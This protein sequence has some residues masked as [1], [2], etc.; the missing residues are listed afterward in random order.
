MELFQWVIE[1]VAVQRDGVND[2]YVFQIT[3]FD[4]SEKN[5]MDIARMKTKRMLKRNKIPYLRITICWVQLVAVI[6]RTKY[7][8]Y[9]QLV[10]LNKPKKV[11]T[12]LLQLSF[13]ELD[14]YERRYRK[15]RRKKHKR[16]ANLN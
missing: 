6:R 1:T 11:L 3:T 7:E 5:A 8:E 15:E 13:W 9:K 2:M 12:R 16:Q 14:E 4:K 10:R